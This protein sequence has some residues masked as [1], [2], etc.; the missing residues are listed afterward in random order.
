MV[1]KLLSLSVVVLL[2]MISLSSCKEAGPKTVTLVITNNSPYSIVSLYV[3]AAVDPQWGDIR[4]DETFDPGETINI[5][6]TPDETWQKEKNW[7]VGFYDKDE[8]WIESPYFNA[9]KINTIGIGYNE[10][11]EEYVFDYSTEEIVTSTETS[12]ETSTD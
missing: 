4:L 1:K 5:N 6:F 9:Y 11:K 7:I 12:S 3:A 2:C 10:E 8:F